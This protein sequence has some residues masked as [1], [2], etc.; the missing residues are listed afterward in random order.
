MARAV[1]IELKLAAKKASAWGTAVAVGAGDGI[2]IRPGNWNKTR[3]N[4]VDDS[5]GLFFPT[6]S[7]P[8]EIKVE[9]G[10]NAYLRYDSLDLLLAMLCGSST[11]AY[12]TPAESG[13][14]TSATGTTLV[15]TGLAMTPDEHIGSFIAITGGLG[16]G[17]VRKITDNDATSFTVLTWTTTPDATSTYEVF[18]AGEIDA[19]HIY[20][21]VAS[22]DGLF[23]TIAE[24][25]VVN[26]AELPSV[27]IT[28]MTIKGEVGK[29]LDVSFDLVANDQVND[30][31]TNT[32]VS[33]GSV[34]Y[35]ETANRVLFRHGVFRINDQDG[36][37]LD[38][39][40]V[41]Y[42]SSFEFNF[43]R[44]MTGVFGVGGS[45]DVIDEPS[46][47]GVPEVGVKLDFP[48]YTGAD[49]FIDWEAGQAK[50]LDV[51]FTGAD[52]RS[53]TI[54]F[55]NLKYSTVAVPEADGILKNPCEFNAL[56]CLAAPTGMTNLTAPFRMTLVNGF[57]GDPLQAGN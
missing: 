7:D 5:L 57:G 35:R 31:A 24:N 42:P 28:G 46:N 13:T 53:L 23:L 54:E 30:S 43:K 15:D 25:R 22:T 47:D 27:K 44:K 26:V 34:T 3:P 36:D 1:G 52:G 9:G 51:V 45:S 10:L 6:D 20:L 50:K 39:G 18:D 33:F 55:P 19:T 41:I 40:D 21:P 49:H 38:S 32:L 17:Q 29:P 48:R 37:A 12:G 11:V 2:L 14:A 4:N 16:S 56:G 8:G